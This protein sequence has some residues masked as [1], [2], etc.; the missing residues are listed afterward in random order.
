MTIFFNICLKSFYLIIINKFSNNL[1]IKNNYNFFLIIYIFI[2]NLSKFVVL[3]LENTVFYLFVPP[4]YNF[5]R[6]GN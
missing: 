3:L 1:I 6:R 4:A 2:V 5:M